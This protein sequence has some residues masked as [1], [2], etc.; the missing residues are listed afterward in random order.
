MTN[1]QCVCVCV[2]ASGSQQ[3]DRQECWAVCVDSVTSRGILT[4]GAQAAGGRAACLSELGHKPVAKLA[5]ARGHEDCSS[6]APRCLLVD[7]RGDDHASGHIQAFSARFAH[8]CFG[9]GW[10]GC[11]EGVRVSHLSTAPGRGARAHQFPGTPFE[12]GGAAQ[13]GSGCSGNMGC[14]SRDLAC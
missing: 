10:T 11:L 13:R 7:V 5:K 6:K 8:C 14:S 2:F 9:L 12:P 1:A 3:D 4:T